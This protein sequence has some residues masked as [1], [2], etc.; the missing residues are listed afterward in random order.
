MSSKQHCDAM[1]YWLKEKGVSS[2]RAGIVH[3]LAERLQVFLPGIYEL[4]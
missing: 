2:H 4:E 3:A 1:W